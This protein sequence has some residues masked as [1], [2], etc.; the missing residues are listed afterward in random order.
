MRKTPRGTTVGV[1][2]PYEFVDRCD[3]VTDDGLCRFAVEHASVDPDFSEERA[4]DGYRCLALPAETVD[5]ADP[6]WRRCPHF[7]CRN[8]GH[9]CARC[10]LER[11]PDHHTGARPLLETHHL[12]YPDETPQRSNEDDE[13]VHEITI[14]LCRWCHAKVHNSWASLADDVRPDPEAIAERETRR[15]K[16][17]DELDFDTAAD[18]RDGDGRDDE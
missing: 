2:D 6:T 7:R 13:L 12:S 3:Y 9:A 17:M 16:E 8:V 5:D 1:D 14:E 15:G 18:R 4:S 11:R 10:G